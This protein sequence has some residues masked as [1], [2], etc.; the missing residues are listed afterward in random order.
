MIQPALFI[1]KE[2]LKKS[3]AWVKLPGPSSLPSSLSILNSPVVLQ[4]VTVCLQLG[5]VHAPN[6]RVNREP[7]A[8]PEPTQLLTQL[9]NLAKSKIY[10]CFRKIR[11]QPRAMHLFCERI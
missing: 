2:K 6:S 10:L 9:T 8:H 7:A 1:P 4:R 5:S 11:A 3:S